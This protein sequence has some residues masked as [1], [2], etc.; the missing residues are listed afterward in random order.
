[1]LYS[2]SGQIQFQFQHSR[3]QDFAE[4]ER[5]YILHFTSGGKFPGMVLRL[6]SVFGDK[7]RVRERV[8]IEC[9]WLHYKTVAAGQVRML[10]F[11]QE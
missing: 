10:D 6:Q 4:S 7:Q 2:D 11:V 9:A 8:D 3:Q 5:S 1:M